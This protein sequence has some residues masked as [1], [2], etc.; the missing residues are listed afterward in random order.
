MQARVLVALCVSICFLAL[1]LVIKPF[2]RC[3]AALEI[4]VANKVQSHRIDSSLSLRRPEDGSLMMLIELAL[5][6]IY[7]C[8]L[9]IKTCNMSM[10]TSSSRDA[11]T[12]ARALCSSYGFGETSSGEQARRLSRPGISAQLI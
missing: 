8:V 12:I 2:K 9:V 1:R 7:V 10:T 5:V 4:L 6:L 3:A 11:D